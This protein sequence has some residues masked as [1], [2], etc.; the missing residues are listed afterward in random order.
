MALEE[1]LRRPL[2][3]H[4]VYT[5]LDLAGARLRE[6]AQGEAATEAAAAAPHFAAELRALAVLAGLS[7]A[8]A[9]P[10]LTRTT[11]VGPLMRRK[12][13]PLLGPVLGEIAVLRGSA[14][15]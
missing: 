10:V 11:A 4:I 7:E 1:V 14:G 12:L 5:A 9:V 2:T 8:T 6:L 13:E 15:G 3:H